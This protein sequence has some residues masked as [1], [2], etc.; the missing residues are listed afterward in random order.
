MLRFSNVIHKFTCASILFRFLSCTNVVCDST[1]LI[2]RKLG[3]PERPKKPGTAYNR[4]VKEKL[5]LIAR[6]ASSKPPKEVMTIAAE[7]WKKLDDGQKRKYNEEYQKEMVYGHNNLHIGFV[8]DSQ[9]YCVN[10]IYFSGC[11]PEREGSI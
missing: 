10:I 4:F 11:V 2:L 7:Q 8:M 1:N 6:D 9:T 3:I 5:P